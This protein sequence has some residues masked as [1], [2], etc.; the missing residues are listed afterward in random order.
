MQKVNLIWGKSMKILQL[1]IKIKIM[2]KNH[3]DD[4]YVDDE[5]EDE[6]D[7][8]IEEEEEV[9]TQKVIQN[10]INEKKNKKSSD[11][12]VNGNGVKI[13][14]YNEKKFEEIFEIIKNSKMKGTV[15]DILKKSFEMLKKI[16]FKLSNH[17]ENYYFNDKEIINLKEE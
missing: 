17:K 5:F 16:F 9:E 2:N 7:H 12:K 13:A 11:I 14:F 10:K 6:F 8:V 1:K 3:I 15:L 4:D